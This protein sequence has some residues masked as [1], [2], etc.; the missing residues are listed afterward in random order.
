LLPVV[1]L[2]AQRLLAESAA[3]GVVLGIDTGGPIGSFGVVA[4]GRLAAAVI[5]S[6]LSH[7]LDL[8]AAVNE[9]LNAA[10]ASLSDLAAIAVAVGPGSFTGLRVGL[11]YAKGIAAAKKISI[12]GVSSLDALALCAGSGAPEG[13]SVYPVID[14][15]RGEV[16]TGLYRVVA[17]ALEKTSDDLV[18]S[19]AHLVAGLAEEAVFVGYS[20]AQQAC[21]L[22]RANGRR[23]VL[24]DNAGLHLRGSFV[25]AIGAAKV[26]RKE[27]DV[28]ATLEPIYL[29]APDPATSFS[30]LKPGE[31]IHG[32]PRG[33]TYPATPWSRQRA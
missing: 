10:G 11:S 14:A 21:S 15:R 13:A 28:I 9:A 33:R 7:G 8:P 17:G 18:V 32:T 5:R 24:I 3:A 19:L 16:Y 23:A 1:Q 31:E 22:A 12:V 4:E 26:G 25:A 30:G 29:R 6:P 27:T 2:S 20:V